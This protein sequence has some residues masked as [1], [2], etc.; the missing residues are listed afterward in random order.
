MSAILVVIDA[1]GIDAT[2]ADESLPETAVSG[3]V[4]IIM[5]P[6]IVRMGNHKIRNEVATTEGY[7]NARTYWSTKFI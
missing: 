5:L 3:T 7:Y 2:M 6:E 4:V 1:V